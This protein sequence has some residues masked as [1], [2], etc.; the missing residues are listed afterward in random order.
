[1]LTTFYEL[2]TFVFFIYFDIPSETN[3]QSI[4]E[5]EKIVYLGLV[6]ILC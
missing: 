4:I 5:F 1:M 3:G 2:K 6:H